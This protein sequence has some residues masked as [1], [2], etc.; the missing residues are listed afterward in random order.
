MTKATAVLILFAFSV[1]GFPCPATAQSSADFVVRW[2]PNSEPNVTTY[3]IYRSL[4]RD[5]GYAAIDSVGAAATSYI[6]DGLSFGVRYYYRVVA[7]NSSGDRSSFSAPVSGAIIAQDAP[8]NVQDLCRI[9][10]IDSVG[11][12]RY[13]IDWSTQDQTIGFVQYDYNWPLDSMSAWDDDQYELSHTADIY[14]LSARTYYV[15]AVSYDSQ[16]NMTVSAYDSL[17]VSGE[18]PAPLAAPE[19][20]IYPVP[21]HPG[22][23]NGLTLTNLPLGG[24]LAIFNERGLEVW[25]SDVSAESLL[26]NGTNRQ[27]AV[28]SSGVYYIMV[29]DPQGRVMET[30]PIILVR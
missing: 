18:S 17:S 23:N 7:K 3:I 28:V 8:S 12:A 24:T 20:S 4:S 27:G 2:I 14:N 6:D 15:R 19:V 29:K 30:R 21:F 10:E 11:P 25:R 13:A 26:W 1:I 5:G 22:M 9:I 16:K